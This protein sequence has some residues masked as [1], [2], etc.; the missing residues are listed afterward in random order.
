MKKKQDAFYIKKKR[1]GFWAWLATL[2]VGLAVCIGAVVTLVSHLEIISLFL[3]FSNEAQKPGISVL[4]FGVDEAGSAR[5]SDTVLFL[6]LNQDTNGLWALSIPRDTRVW[7]ENQGY[8]RIN[9]A[10]AHGGVPLLQQTVESFLAVSINYYVKVNLAG[11][12]QFVDRIGG[13]PLTVERP[14]KYQDLAGD[15]DIDIKAGPQLLDGKTAIEYVR[16]RYDRDGDI[17]R[18]ARQQYFLEAA[19]NKIFSLKTVFQLPFIIKAV[20][21]TVHTNLSL[22][23]MYTLSKQFKYVLQQGNVTKDTLP[24]QTIQLGG[25]YYWEPHQE[26]LTSLK[27]R[28]FNRN[29]ANSE[30]SEQQD[31]H[32]ISTNI[33]RIDQPIEVKENSGKITQEYYRSS[34]ELDYQDDFMYE[35][36]E[37]LLSQSIDQFLN[38]ATEELAPPVGGIVIS[39]EI[40]FMNNAAR[41]EQDMPMSDE[42]MDSRADREE[43]AAPS[44]LVESYRL[45]E[46]LVF[47]DRTDYLKSYAQNNTRTAIFNVKDKKRVFFRGKMNKKHWVRHQY[48][49]KEQHEIPAG[50]FLNTSKIRRGITDVD[51]AYYAR[52]KS[53]LNLS[54][55]QGVTVEI[56]NGTGN[57]EDSLRAIIVLEQLGLHVA[58]VGKAGHSQY[59]NTKIVDWKA[60]LLPS[61]LLA[62]SLKIDHEEII[63]YHRHNKPIDLT[64]V[65][66]SDWQ[67]FLKDTVSL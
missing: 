48:Y 29:T 64:I 53:I 39:E 8:T 24:G 62:E 30:S 60:Q 50:L 36:N 46:E 37:G 32:S 67:T 12:R 52:F 3:N 18:I 26:Q 51:R 6:Y 63:V 15:L 2:L 54:Y 13:V 19:I 59:K 10:Y 14:M 5:R 33:T 28:A 25:A 44:P 31:T 56:L 65:L 1:S 55:L 4:L 47:D 57:E 27:N 11:V 9:H 7:V 40:G 17:G 49:Q 42:G 58:H 38:K 35:E 23:E 61:L 66:G 22:S 20:T 45:T 34:E 43:S 16:F 41:A 21:D